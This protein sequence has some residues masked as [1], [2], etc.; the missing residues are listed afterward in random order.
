MLH[1][2]CI[3]TFQ[4]RYCVELPTDSGQCLGFL[5]LMNS[6]VLVFLRLFSSL[7]SCSRLNWLSYGVYVV[8]FYVCPVM[9]IFCIM[10]LLG[11][12]YRCFVLRF[13]VFVRYQN[14][15]RWGNQ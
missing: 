5:V 12:L 13:N 4:I 6:L 8:L 2:L 1:K 15:E 9:L 3:F 10:L 7:V 14:L 11:C